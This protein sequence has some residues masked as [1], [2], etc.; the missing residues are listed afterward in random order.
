MVVILT[1]LMG[2]SMSTISLKLLTSV[3]C[4]AK[5]SQYNGHIVAVFLTVLMGVSVGVSLSMTAISLK[6]RH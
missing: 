2:V 3:Y 5:C 1:V 4:I 6:Y